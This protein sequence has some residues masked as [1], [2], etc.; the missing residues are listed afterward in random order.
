MHLEF[1]VKINLIPSKRFKKERK[2]NKIVFIFFQQGF[3]ICGIY[4][5]IFFIVSYRFNEV[6]EAVVAVAADVDRET[7]SNC[8]D[9]CLLYNG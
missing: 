2:K 9:N 1:K 4:A 5:K 3:T 6:G 8:F 7:L